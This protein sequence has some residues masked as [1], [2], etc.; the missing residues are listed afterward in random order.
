MTD[1][2]KERVKGLRVLERNKE[3]LIMSPHGEKGGEGWPLFPLS[4]SLCLTRPVHQLYGSR[5]NDTQPP[6]QI[7]CWRWISMGQPQNWSPRR[8]QESSPSY[9]GSH[10]C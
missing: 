5:H 9:C 2:T 1:F 8:G 10:H 4:A 7:E 3:K 6:P